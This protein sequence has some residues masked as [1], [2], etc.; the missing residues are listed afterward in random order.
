MT[1][2]VSNYLADKLL[3][4]TFR[5]QN[6]VSPS[7][8]YIA[9]YTSNPTAADTGTEVSGGDYARQAVVFGAPADDS[10]KRTIKNTADI[11]YPVATA[12]WGTVTHVGIRDGASAGNLLFYGAVDNPRSILTADALKMLTGNVA[13]SLN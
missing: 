12:D 9:L 10:G 13:C 4:A 5:G 6:Y 3:N 2:A 1:L 7:T 8:V 11:V